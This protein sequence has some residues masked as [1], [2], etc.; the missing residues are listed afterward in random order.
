MYNG[1]LDIY[2]KLLIYEEDNMHNR[3]LLQC[4]DFLE[5]IKE[6]IVNYIL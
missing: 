6:K 2:R 3:K 4:T 1:I 5:Y